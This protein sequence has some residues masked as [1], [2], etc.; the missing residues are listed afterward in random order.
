LPADTAI[1]ENSEPLTYTVLN[2][3]Q[4]AL[5]ITFAPVVLPLPG[6]KEGVVVGVG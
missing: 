5:V 1:A 4:N 2:G 3:A 6:M